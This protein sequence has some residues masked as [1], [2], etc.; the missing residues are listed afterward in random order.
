MGN[1][2]DLQDLAQEVYLRLLRVEQPE[3]INNPQSYIYRVALNVAEEWRLRAAQSMEHSSDLLDTLESPGSNQEQLF[4]QEERQ[5][6]MR[7]AMEALPSATRNAMVLHVQQDMTYEQVAEHMG[8][9]RRAV[10]RYIAKGYAST[11]AALSGIEEA[12][13]PHRGKEQR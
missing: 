13:G 9:S 5:K 6:V 4:E 10:K 2:A 12:R 8:V 1:S 3:L 7:S 11:R